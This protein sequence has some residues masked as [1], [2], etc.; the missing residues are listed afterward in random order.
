M[1]AWSHQ[2]TAGTRDRREANAHDVTVSTPFDT[3]FFRDT[4]LRLLV[5][6][7]VLTA[8]SRLLA[9]LAVGDVRYDK[10]RS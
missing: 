4:H 6:P 5:G 7:Y 1:A 8:A 10:E 9:R 3:P 2:A